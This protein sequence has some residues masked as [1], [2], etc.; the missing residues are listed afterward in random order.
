M[1]MSAV[2]ISSGGF[3]ENK[4]MQFLPGERTQ[5]S[6][7]LRFYNKQTNKQKNPPSSSPLCQQGTPLESSLRWDQEN[8]LLE[9]CVNVVYLVVWNFSPKLEST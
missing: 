3:E 5:E 2:A 9:A 1:Q 4:K 6:A 8:K 7:T